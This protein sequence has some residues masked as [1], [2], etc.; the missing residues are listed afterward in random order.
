METMCFY[1]IKWSDFETS[2]KYILF[3]PNCPSREGFIRDIREVAETVVD[4]LVAEETFI[5]LDDFV[6]KIVEKLKE[7]GYVEPE[8]KATITLWS[9]A[10]T[11]MECNDKSMEILGE[12]VCRKIHE[13]NKK[14]DRKLVE[15][16]KEMVKNNE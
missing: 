14:I 11:I 7:K 9:P 6:E 10:F 13:H 4:E 3:N 12:E 15:K 2:E 16:F 5:S 1:I 8:P